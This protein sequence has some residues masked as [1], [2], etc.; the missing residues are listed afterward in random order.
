MAHPSKTNRDD[1]L[2]MLVDCGLMGIETY[3]HGQTQASVRK[4]KDFALKHHLVC[5]GGA[6]FHVKRPDGRNAPGSLKVPYNVLDLLKEAK[7]ERHPMAN[8]YSVE[9]PIQATRNRP[10]GSNTNPSSPGFPFP[11]KSLPSFSDPLR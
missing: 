8:R 11:K 5:S 3:C 10:E 1:L 9:C 4:Y 7:I 2:E 6:D